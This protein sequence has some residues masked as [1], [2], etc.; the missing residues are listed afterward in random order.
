MLV[1]SRKAN[2][3]LLIGQ[4][5]EVVILEVK[6][7]IVRLGINAPRE[8]PVVRTELA[9]KLRDEKEQRAIT[10]PFEPIN[11]LSQIPTANGASDQ[12]LHSFCERRRNWTGPDIANVMNLAAMLPEC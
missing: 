10:V 12:L 8:I 6:G 5:I 1:L 7:N 4:N 2:E 11:R 3:R 9:E